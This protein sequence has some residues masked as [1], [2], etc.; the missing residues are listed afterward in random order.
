[1]NQS[2]QK[3]LIMFFTS[4]CVLIQMNVVAQSYTF[5]PSKNFTASVDTSELNYNGIYITNTGVTDLD[6][7]WELFLNDTLIDCEFDLCNSGIC[8]SYLPI[9]GS[10]PKILPTQQ[11]FLKLHMFSGRTT[12]VNTI[13]YILKNSILSSSDTLTFKINVGD[14]TGL[15][16]LQNIKDVTLYPNPSSKQTSIHLTLGESSLITVNAINAL[17]ETVS[18]ATTIYST[19]SHSIDFNTENWAS[20]IYSI[21][22]ISPNGHISKKLVVSNQ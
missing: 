10:L 12:G 6:F 8:F 18:V 14:V 1:M 5:S 19:G 22:L 15:N 7:T 4:F 16:E 13:K 3:H 11:G 9:T 2:L 20:G 21:Q 17:G